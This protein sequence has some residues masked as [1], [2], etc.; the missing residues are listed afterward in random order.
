MTKEGKTFFEVFSQSGVGKE[1]KGSAG[2]RPGEDLLVVSE[3]SNSN[4]PKR[5]WRGPY[6]VGL[7]TIVLGAVGGVLL[8]VGCF[9]LGH[10]LGTYKALS[11]AQAKTEKIAYNEKTIPKQASSSLKPTSASS[12]PASPVSKANHEKPQQVPTET[13]KAQH[14]KPQQASTEKVSLTPKTVAPSKDIWSL[15]VISFK[16]GTKS[17]EKA[18]DLAKVLKERTGQSAFVAKQGSQIVV[19]VGEFDSKDSAQL[20]E[21]QKQI[22]EFKHE[23]KVQFAGCYPVRVK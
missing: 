7:E 18:S 6:R 15:R 21:L 9:F 19:C 5:S 12:K 14:E 23:G 20:T 10:K 2:G 22:K 8:A 4:K 16:E 11:K 17:E 13:A 3:V 1:G